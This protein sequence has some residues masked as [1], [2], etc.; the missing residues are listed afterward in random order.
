MKLH[1]IFSKILCINRAF[2]TDRWEHCQAQALK[3]GLE[4][5]RFEAVEIYNEHGLL[6]WNSCTASHRACLEIA[7]KS[8]G[9]VLILED[10][11]KIRFDDFHLLFQSMVSFVPTDW[12]LLYLGGHY[13]NPPLARVAPCVL[14]CDRMMG[15]SSYGIMPV[16]AARIL[17]HMR[18]NHQADCVVSD[19]ASVHLHYIFQPRL[20]VQ[21]ESFS[22]LC[23]QVINPAL[24]MTDTVHEN[25][26]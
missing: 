14:R 7:S 9:P 2:R 24:S 3:F 5:E 23:Q 4:L 12:D 26:L 19:F 13:G 16:H 15:L 21:Y 18:T 10:D 17:S 22:D 20:I 11:F 25:L 8:Q 1:E 6:T